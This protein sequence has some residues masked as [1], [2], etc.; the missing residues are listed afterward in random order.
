MKGSEFSFDYFH[1][2]YYKYYKNN[3]NRGG[4]YV[5]S[6][7][8]IRN[9]KATINPIIKKN[10]KC[11]QYAVIVESNHEEMGKNL[12]RIAKIRPK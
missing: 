8:W 9:K 5:D 4:S 6:P 2:L 11:F 3:Q 12:K 1:L 7:A 10:N